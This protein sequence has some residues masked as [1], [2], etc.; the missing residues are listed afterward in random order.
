MYR[1]EILKNKLL[2][3]ENLFGTNVL[4]PEAATCEL[5]GKAGCD[6]V[7]IDM[8]HGAIDYKDAYYQVI[9]AHAGNAAAIIRVTGNDPDIMKKVLDMG[10]D[11]VIFP[12]VRS[13]QEARTVI[14]SCLY[15]PKGFRGFNPYAAAD[16]SMEKHPQ[17]CAES[18]DSVLRIV[19]M[20]HIDAY[21]ELDAILEIEGL[22][23]LMLGPSDLSG[24]LNKLLKREDPEVTAI[25]TDTVKRARAAGKFVGIALGFNTPA[26]TMRYWMDMGVHMISFGQDVDI[27]YLA[28]TSKLKELKMED[29]K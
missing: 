25:I 4:L 18:A 20:E 1:A 28:I 16:Y 14:Q 8:E 6:F 3:D 22:D 21:R 9:A 27:M 29:G 26:E 11:G 19:M 7:W 17:Y 15:P 10:A 12:M 13:A 24:S 23:G 2:S 5:M